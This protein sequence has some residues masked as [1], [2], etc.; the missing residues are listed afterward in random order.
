MTDVTIV[1]PDVSTGWL[2]VTEAAKVLGVSRQ[3]IHQ[4]IQSG[5]LK[6][7]RVQ[8]VTAAKFHYLLPADQFGEASAYAAPTA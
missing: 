5:S 1:T 7:E 3:R 8:S 2:T 4:R 6:A